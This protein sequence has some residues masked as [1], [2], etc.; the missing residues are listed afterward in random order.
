MLPQLEEHGD[1]VC[2]GERLGAVMDHSKPTLLGDASTHLDLRNVRPLLTEFEGF[3]GWSPV[4]P[5]VLLGREAG[6]V[7]LEHFAAVNVCLADLVEAGGN[8]VGLLLERREIGVS[9][10]SSEPLL[11]NISPPV[12]VSQLPW[13]D[14]LAKALV[15]GLSSGAQTTADLVLESTARHQPVLLKDGHESDVARTTC[16]PSDSAI[17]A[18]GVLLDHLSH[19]IR[20]GSQLRRNQVG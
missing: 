14:A 17:L 18:W 11:R 13:G 7:N 20:R 3:P 1:H 6:L 10:A 5:V 15:E 8:R 4:P 2:M 19:V 9:R 16:S 12:Y